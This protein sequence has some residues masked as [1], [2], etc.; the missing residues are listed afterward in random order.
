MVVSMLRISL[1]ECSIVTRLSLLSYYITLLSHCRCLWKTGLDYRHYIT[2]AM[3]MLT[4]SQA[5][6][7]QNGTEMRKYSRRQCCP[8]LIDPLE[9]SKKFI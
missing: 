4:F 9:M 2:G 3:F 7:T 1:L 6:N 5:W 8:G